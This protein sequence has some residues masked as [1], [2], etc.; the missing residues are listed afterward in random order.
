M[1]G[2]GF[3]RWGYGAASDGLLNVKRSSESAKTD[4]QTTPMGLSI[5]GIVKLL[6]DRRDS[7]SRLLMPIRYKKV[8]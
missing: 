6:K 2:H 5:R 1:Q 4:F 7:V 8:V 3:S